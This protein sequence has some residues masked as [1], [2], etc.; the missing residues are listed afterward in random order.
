MEMITNILVECIELIP[1][2]RVGV[3]E[4][5][6]LLAE[7]D[8]CNL[9]FKRTSNIKIKDIEW[10]DVII[11]VRGS[12]YST[13]RIVEIAKRLGKFIIYFLD[14]DLLNIPQDCKSTLYYSSHD[15]K[16][17]IIAIIGYS[18]I[19]WCV[20]KNIALKYS[21]YCNNNYAIERVPVEISKYNPIKEES[22]IRIVY[23]GSVDHERE[24]KEFIS[25]AV[26]K[27][28]KEL[29]EKVEFTFIGVN[30]AISGIKNVKYIE[31][32]DS[33]DS[34]KKIMS[35]SS[36]NI[37]ISPIYETEFYKCKYYNK[38]IEYTSINVAGI[39]TNSEPY[40]FVVQNEVNGFL[41][42]NS[43]A[44]WYEALKKIITNE[45]L[46]KKCII[47]ARVLVEKDFSYEIVTDRLIKDIPQLLNY[48]SPKMY[49]NKVYLR[50]LYSLKVFD[51][52]K[53]WWNLYNI[54]IVPMVFKKI[55]NKMYKSTKKYF[56]K[57]I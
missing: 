19:L 6:K 45:E 17:N 44:E 28:C 42:N 16:S 40:N 22:V 13:L 33:Y 56:G 11:S 3:L 25:P 50:F 36:F 30:P 8:R 41:V 26:I 5:L 4:P 43:S 47:N 55:V 57:N 21:K 52:I 31:Y 10:A 23:A 9:Q 7:Q 35:G 34:Y 2:V 1:S 24:I 20:N 29:G 54:R 53:L 49:V 12:E 15:I 37:G 27:I 39:Y 48:K 14:D 18:N 32:I 38:F 51:K 46:R